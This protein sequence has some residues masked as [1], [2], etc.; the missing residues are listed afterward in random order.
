[1]SSYRPPVPPHQYKR[2]AYHYAKEFKLSSVLGGLQS[3]QLA[4]GQVGLRGADSV[5]ESALLGELTE[6]KK[7]DGK[8]KF[9][10]KPSNDVPHI[11]TLSMQKLLT[12][13]GDPLSSWAIDQ[14][15]ITKSHALWMQGQGITY[16]H[17][18]RE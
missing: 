15:Q 16:N 18:K 6:V 10:T 7:T 5:D 17:T 14:M 9:Y 4:T 11:H 8:K 13:L 2:P 12:N 3:Y 1:M